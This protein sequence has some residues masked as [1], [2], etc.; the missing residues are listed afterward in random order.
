MVTPTASSSA[1]TVFLV[2][3][4]DYWSQQHDAIVD[5]QIA[6]DLDEPLRRFV[7]LLIVDLILA[8]AGYLAAFDPRPSE[9]HVQAIPA[10]AD[11]AN[12]E[13]V[14]THLTLRR[15]REL[16]YDFAADTQIP[17][18]V[19]VYRAARGSDPERY[20]PNA[21]RV[22]VETLATPTAFNTVRR[23][24]NMLGVSGKWVESSHEGW[25]SQVVDAD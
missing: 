2:S 15:A 10:D 22:E 14:I 25:R 6:P 11:T 5:G 24:A 12:I 16:V 21:I 20:P 13:F 18:S 8:R 3:D 7:G 23:L 19:A 9:D 1:L 4:T 17:F